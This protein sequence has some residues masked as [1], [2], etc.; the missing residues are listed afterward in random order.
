MDK[1]LDLHRGVGAEKSD[2]IP[3]QLPADHHPGHAQV[4]GGLSAVQA[5]DGHLGAGV[6]GQVRGHLAGHPGHAQVLD[7]QSVHAQPA[8][9]VHQA[10]GLGQLPVAE[11]G[12]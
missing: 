7:Q 6:E 2:L 1:A 12:I 10:G 9:P 3:G 5:V 4:G 8:G 11:E